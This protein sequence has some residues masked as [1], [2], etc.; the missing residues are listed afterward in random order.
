MGIGLGIL[1]LVIGLVL[2]FQVVPDIPNVNDATLGWILVAV[3]A[4]AVILSLIVNA[5]R[6]NTRHVEERRYDDRGPR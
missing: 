3:G 6:A 2:V 4:L 1:L 5:Q